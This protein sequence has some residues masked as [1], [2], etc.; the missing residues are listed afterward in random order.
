ML[1]TDCNSPHKREADSSRSLF[2]LCCAWATVAPNRKKRKRVDTHFRPALELSSFIT[3]AGLY[4]AGS[5]QLR[6]RGIHGKRETKETCLRVAINFRFT[7]RTPGRKRG[8][9]EKEE[10]QDSIDPEMVAVV[11]HTSIIQN[12]LNSLGMEVGALLLYIWEDIGMSFIIHGQK[13]SW[14][15][16]WPLYK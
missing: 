14:E 15:I 6:A 12:R 16:E 2:F 13:P 11:V 9:R 4:I 3:D 10:H 1:P 7:C 5:R 8:E